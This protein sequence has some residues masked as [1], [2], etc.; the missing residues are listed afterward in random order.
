[1]LFVGDQLRDAWNCAV[2]VL[3]FLNSYVN[4]TNTLMITF[5]LSLYL[6]C[7]QSTVCGDIVA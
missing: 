5:H 6:H 1:M 3:S 7:A 2:G 4:Q